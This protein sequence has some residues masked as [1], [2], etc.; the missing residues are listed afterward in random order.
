MPRGIPCRVGCVWRRSEGYREVDYLPLY[1]D[2]QTKQPGKSESRQARLASAHNAA[3]AASTGSGG[4]PDMVSRGISRYR[5]AS[6]DARWACDPVPAAG[7]RRIPR[8]SAFRMRP[9]VIGGPLR[10]AKHIVIEIVIF[11]LVV[12]AVSVG[13]YYLDRG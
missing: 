9:D 11:L 5:A 13:S 8:R 7:F 4:T 12:T 1:F 2:T 3:G 6:A 10:Q